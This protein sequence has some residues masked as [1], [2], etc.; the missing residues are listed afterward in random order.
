[1]L[2]FLGTL[3]LLQHLPCGLGIWSKFD[4]VRPF[5]GAWGST[6]TT[7]YVKI[8]QVEG[9]GPSQ[10][11]NYS[12]FGCSIANIGDLDK[13]GID[14]LAVG[15]RG[16]SSFALKGVG[17]NATYTE[18]LDA[19]A[20]Y[21]LFLTDIG[22][23]RDSVRIGS[24]ENG[25]PEL[26]DNDKFG[27]SIAVVGDLDLDGN[28]DIAVGAPGYL[29]GAVYLLYMNSNGS[30]HSFATIRGA[31]NNDTSEPTFAPT[32]GV[33]STLYPTNPTQLPTKSPVRPTR[34]PTQK[35]SAR[36][37]LTPVPSSRPSTALPTTNTYY[38]TP[39]P[40]SSVPTYKPS[41][42]SM[43]PSQS[44]TRYKANGPPLTF[45]SLF[46]SSL[47]TIGDLNGDGIPD[48]A[49][50][51][52]HQITGV[53]TVFILFLDNDGTVLDYT[54]INSNGAGG[55]PVIE[56]LFN[57]FGSSITPFVD[58]DRDNITEL[59]IGAQYS[60]DPGTNK[61]QSG[62][63]YV[64]Y[65]SRNGTIKSYHM[66]SQTSSFEETG[67]SIPL[68]QD[69]NCGASV[70][71]IG[72]INK[73]DYRQHWPW[74][75]STPPRPSYPDLIMGCPQ[76]DVAGGTGRLFMLFMGNNNTILAE[77]QVPDE[78]YDIARNIAP[79][80]QPLDRFGYSMAAYSDIDQNGIRE[81]A[82]GAPGDHIEGSEYVGA[83][84]ILFHRRRRFH[85]PLVCHLCYLLSFSIPLG[86]IALTCV[87][88]T[89]YFFW[90]YRRKP[91][92][93][94]QIV[95]GSGIEIGTTRVRKRRVT[96][97]SNEA[98]VGADDF[99]F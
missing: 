73:D 17:I 43:E 34:R 71:F 60:V 61:Y 42:P 24:L 46:G 53:N 85:P 12:F 26:F 16:E 65:M 23:V 72:D 22:T 90:H 68:I 76:N 15:A 94:E 3:L 2:L 13:D 14:D 66:I 52:P 10:L 56:Y 35:P 98:K 74:L 5:E 11:S 88:S 96:V 50:G 97:T 36:P 77:K 49:V 33:G 75:I 63:L 29:L 95:L 48:L 54:E 4:L 44:P 8:N 79:V 1:M 41:Q 78:D 59:V 87:C 81:I 58:L 28:V 19:G 62:L 67:I 30:A 40:S 38:P 47:G 39:V 21:I 82:V 31:Y 9:N 84:Y 89:I 57:G 18:Q 93:I 69:D 99:E 7:P 6:F 20:I 51:Q 91:D 80:F 45:A 25:G 70:A 55:G 86:F 92:A 32:T 37:S 27:Y 64:C 83:I